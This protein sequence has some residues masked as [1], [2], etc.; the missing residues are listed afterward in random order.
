MGWGSE[1][2]VKTWGGERNELSALGGVLATES[3]DATLG[4]HELHL[5][6]VERV[7]HGAHVDAEVALA[8]ACFEA[9]TAGAGDLGGDVLGVNVLFHDGL[10]KQPGRCAG[11]GW[12]G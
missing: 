5:A 7:A 12:S 3:F 8:G 1:D 9:G 6:S 4:V 11:A 10:I 2:M